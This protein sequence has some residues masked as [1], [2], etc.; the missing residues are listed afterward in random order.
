MRILATGFEPFGGE[1][2]NPSWMAVVRLSEDVK[3]AEI[4]K[5]QLPVV[6]F[7]ALEVLE[8]YIKEYRPDV[9]LLL[10]ARPEAATPSG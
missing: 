4:I 8:G 9:V 5:K 1:E 6:Y 7:R 2:V 10:P 3:G